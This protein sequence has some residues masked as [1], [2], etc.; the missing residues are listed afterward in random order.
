LEVFTLV[1]KRLAEHRSQRIGEAVAVI[2]RTTG[3]SGGVP[4]AARVSANCRTCS[5]VV[6]RSMRNPGGAR[7]LVA[8][9]SKIRRHSRLGARSEE[10]PF[11]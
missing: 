5:G 3:G 8:R 4:R 6:A 2:E 1:Q 10:P 7:S 9:L 11:H